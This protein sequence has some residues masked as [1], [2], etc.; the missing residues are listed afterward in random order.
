MAKKPKEAKL[1][2]VA[3]E[4]TDSESFAP[5]ELEDAIKFLRENSEKRK[6]T[7]SFDIIINLKNMD[8]K[9]EA[10]NTIIALPFDKG[11]DVV[12]GIISDDAKGENVITSRDMEEIAKSP[13]E[14]KKLGKKYDYFVASANLMTAVGKHLGRY[15]APAGKMPRPMPPNTDP[16][17]F[18]KVASKNLTLRNNKQ[19]RLQCMIGTESVDDKNIAGNV[20]A[21][22]TALEKVLPKGKQNIKN[23]MLK[24]TMSRPVKIIVK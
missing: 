22:L 12:V 16:T 9:R 1:E 7:Q 18:V 14:A 2:K 5:R 20:R 10:V 17:N 11:K 6:F 24:L 23:V 3:T 15:L 19:M 4:V 21:I 13:A 8:V